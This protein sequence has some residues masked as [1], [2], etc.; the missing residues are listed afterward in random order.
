MKKY[1]VHPESLYV[2]YDHTALYIVIGVV[3]LLMIVGFVGYRIYVRHKK[4]EEKEILDKINI[5]FIPSE[6]NKNTTL[7]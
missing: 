6:R 7:K 2:N 1:H 5:S 3:V 4:K